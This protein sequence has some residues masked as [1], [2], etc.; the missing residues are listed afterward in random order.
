MA[1][2]RNGTRPQNR[3]AAKP[4]LALSRC[5]PIF[6][7]SHAHSLVPRL[8]VGT[9]RCGD[10]FGGR[11]RASLA[12]AQTRPAW[13]TLG[14]HHRQTTGRD[15][16][17]AHLRARR[18][19]SGR[20]VRHARGRVHDVRRAELGRRNPGAHLQPE[21]ENDPR[22]QC[23]GCRAHRRHAGVFQGP[24]AQVSAGRG[25]PGRAHARQSRRVDG[26]AGGV[27]DAVA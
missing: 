22:D 6:P 3:C 1:R 14:R 2:H 23:A 8:M 9:A 5:S 27:R 18:Q 25:S 21:H 15:G 17:R 16:G 11:A 13:A 12:N 24:E 4:L 10:L 19:R 7:L 26:D 20:R